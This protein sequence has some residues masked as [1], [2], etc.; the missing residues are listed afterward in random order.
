M[1]T[2]ACSTQPG[3]R[4][5]KKAHDKQAFRAVMKYEGS[6]GHLRPFQ[7]KTP[8]TRAAHLARLCH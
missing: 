4:C 8:Y 1:L 6:I 3:Q 2:L 7:Y 5:E